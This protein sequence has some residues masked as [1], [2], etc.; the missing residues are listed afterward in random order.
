VGKEPD[1]QW[2]IAGGPA[3]KVD[4]E[5]TRTPSEV[6]ETLKAA[7]VLGKPIGIYRIV[8]KTPISQSGEESVASGT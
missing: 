7:G 3:L 5:P 8:A 2:Y 1:Y 6:T 4:Y